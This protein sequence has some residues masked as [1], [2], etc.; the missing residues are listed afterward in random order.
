M[1]SVQDT[2]DALN[3]IQ[4]LSNIINSK[5]DQIITKIQNLSTGGGATQAELDA[6][7]ALVVALQGAVGSVDAKADQA[8]AL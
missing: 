8:L 2:L 5:M 6:I 1:A 7:H 3:T 4:A